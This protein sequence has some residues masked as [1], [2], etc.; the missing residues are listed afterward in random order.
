MLGLSALALSLA[1]LTAT[2]SR[3]SAAFR[4]GL[5]V[6]YGADA[7]IE[8]VLPDLAAEADVNRLL[9]GGSI[10]SYADGPPGP[11]T[12]PDGTVVHLHTL[13]QMVSCGKPA[14]SDADLDDE[15]EDRPWGRNN[16]RWQLYGYGPLSSL[17]AGLDAPRVYAVVWVADD[18]SENDDEPLIDGGP[19][20]E[21]SNP[22]RGRLLL[23]AQAYGIS[24]ARRTVEASIAWERGD[25]RMIAWREIR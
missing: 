10:S 13:T 16:P 25:V 2:E 24:G 23:M 11:R 18:P 19:D 15:R 20:E 21:A 5:Q 22:G 12:L 3:V 8:R 6:L 9:A 17:T 14:C 1:L 4:G 7:A